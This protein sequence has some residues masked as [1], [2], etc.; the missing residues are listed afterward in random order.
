MTITTKEMKRNN[1]YKTVLG[2]AMAALIL[3]A[4]T[5]EWDDHYDDKSSSVLGGTL[6]DAIQQD[7]NLSNFASVSHQVKQRHLLL[8]II[9]RRAVWM[10]TKSPL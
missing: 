10:K 6:W 1:I 3:T 2:L 8:L 7:N 9:Q 5:D 4:C